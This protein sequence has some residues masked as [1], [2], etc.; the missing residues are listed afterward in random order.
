MV[1]V[2][3]VTVPC[4]QGSRRSAHENG[5]RDQLLEPGRR[6]EDPLEK[7]TRTHLVSVSAP[8]RDQAF[9]ARPVNSSIVW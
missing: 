2:E 4:V 8:I 7:V 6:L 1:M 9:V 5:V 3:G